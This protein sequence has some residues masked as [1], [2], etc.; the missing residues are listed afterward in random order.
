[1][2]HKKETFYISWPFIFSVLKRFELIR[3]DF[4][5]M[6]FTQLFKPAPHAERLPADR[7]DSEYRKLRLQVFLGIFIGYA[8]YYFVRKNFSLAMPY[9]IEQGFSKGNLGLSFQQF[10]LL[11]D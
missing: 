5:F 1:M 8:G 4:H 10:L 11:T 3:E 7:V 2:N 6:F 9:L